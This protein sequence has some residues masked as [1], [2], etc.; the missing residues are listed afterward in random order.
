MKLYAPQTINEIKKKYEVDKVYPP[1]GLI[2]EKVST[3][4]EKILDEEDVYAP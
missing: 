4:Q 2:I 3:Y 1:D